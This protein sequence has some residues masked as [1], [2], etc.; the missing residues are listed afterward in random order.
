[1][2]NSKPKQ[3]TLTPEDQDHLTRLMHVSRR[4]YDILLASTTNPAPSYIDLAAQFSIPLGTVRSRLSRARQRIH[5]WRHEAVPVPQPEGQQ[6][7][8]T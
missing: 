5:D 6:E 2:R 8:A 3:I 7:Q 4:Q 1:M